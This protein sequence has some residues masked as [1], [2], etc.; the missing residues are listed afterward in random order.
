MITFNIHCPVLDL[1]APVDVVDV[2]GK[3]VGDLGDL[4]EPLDV[5]EEGGKL[6]LDDRIEREQTLFSL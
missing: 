5:F 3:R 2:G 6:S 4:V 1:P